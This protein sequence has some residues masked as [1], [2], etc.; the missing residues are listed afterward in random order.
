MEREYAI[1]SGRLDLCLRYG[2]EA[3]EDGG[4]AGRGGDPGVRFRNLSSAEAT[5][6]PARV[7]VR[8]CIVGMRSGFSLLQD[9]LMRRL[10]TIHNDFAW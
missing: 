4:R 9:E 1:G 8:R 6:I 5:T 10:P 7:N 2:G 3:G